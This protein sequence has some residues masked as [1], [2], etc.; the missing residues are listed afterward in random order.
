MDG[1]IAVSESCYT[2]GDHLDS[3]WP[4]ESEAASECR[5]DSVGADEQPVDTGAN[6]SPDEHF[7]LCYFGTSGRRCS[8]SQLGGRLATTLVERYFHH[9]FPFSPFFPNHDLFS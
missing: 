4:G 8:R 6:I 2:A 7:L 1:A 5:G 9:Y 3:E